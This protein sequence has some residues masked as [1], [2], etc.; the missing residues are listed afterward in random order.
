[1]EQDALAG[2]EVDL[3]LLVGHPWHGAQR[4]PP[5][6][7]LRYPACGRR[8]GEVVASVRVAQL[9]GGCV[10]HRVEAG[11]EHVR[12]D[13]GVQPVVCPLEHGAGGGELPCFAAQD[14]VRGGHDEGGGDAFVR[15]VARDERDP[16]VWQLEE[17]VEIAA[18]LSRR[19]VVGSEAP[20]GEGRHLSGQ[21]LVLDHPR[22]AQL[23]RFAFP[24]FLGPPQPLCGFGHQRAV[25]SHRIAEEEHGDH[26]GSVSNELVQHRSRRPRR[27]HYR[28]EED[29]GEVR[30]GDP[31]RPPEVAG[32]GCRVQ[33]D[34]ERHRR[35]DA[36][37]ASEVV[38]LERNDGRHQHAHGPAPPGKQEGAERR[39][40]R[41]G[42]R[43]GRPGVRSRITAHVD[44]DGDRH[45][46]HYRE[47]GVD[48]V[49]ANAPFLEGGTHVTHQA[50][51][52]RGPPR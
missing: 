27:P 36:R 1:V 10:E 32:R 48:R 25:G 49:W 47:P 18:Y 29:P 50:R 31:H 6:P 14:A 16:A 17:V 12:G 20:A 39:P 5:R 30:G 44:R 33:R 41:V 3:V 4:H 42:E 51:T 8:V 43:V 7:K 35:G 46:D 52:S 22:G 13:V 40:Q 15:D 26:K 28:V 2:G 24:V 9:S 34:G 45:R 37:V 21:Q 11:D 23:S 19:P 38:D